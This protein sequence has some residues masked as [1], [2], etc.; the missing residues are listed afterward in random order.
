MGNCCDSSKETMRKQTKPLS[1][2]MKELKYRIP[3]SQL[4]S[5][6]ENYRKRKL[7]EDIHFLKVEFKSTEKLMSILDTQLNGI[8]E[9]ENIEERINKYGSHVEAYTPSGVS[10]KERMRLDIRKKRDLV[11]VIRDG[12]CVKMSASLLVVGDILKAEK[13]LVLPTDGI[14]VEGNII[15]DESKLS[16]SNQATISKKLP[17]ERCIEFITLNSDSKKFPSPVVLAGSTIV[18]GEGRICI[19]VVGKQCT[20]PSQLKI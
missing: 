12:E 13:M 3:N 11:K 5:I 6:V 1:Y 17:I 7:V 15:T 14:L 2:E 9:R 4:V 19:I 8:S 10:E 18:Q 16:R 20:R